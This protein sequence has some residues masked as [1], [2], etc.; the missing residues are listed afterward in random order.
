MNGI[1]ERMLENAQEHL[2]EVVKSAIEIAQK[3]PDYDMEQVCVS[4]QRHLLIHKAIFKDE[5]IRICEGTRR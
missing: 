4:A 5:E 1:I 2:N 3:N